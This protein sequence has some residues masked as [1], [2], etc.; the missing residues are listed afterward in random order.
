M[1]DIRARLLLPQQLPKVAHCCMPEPSISLP[2]GC[3]NCLCTCIEMR[4]DEDEDET[5]WEP[6]T[7]SKSSIRC[8]RLLFLFYCEAKEIS[9]SG[10]SSTLPLYVSS[11]TY[12]MVHMPIVA[13]WGA[14]RFLFPDFG[15]CSESPLCHSILFSPSFLLCRWV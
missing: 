14:Y 2:P 6:K 4:L 8:H 13:G 12:N 7:R 15:S 10:S 9:F 11:A 1:G 5:N 3:I